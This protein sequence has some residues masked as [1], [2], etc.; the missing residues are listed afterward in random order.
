M[1]QTPLMVILRDYRAEGTVKSDMVSSSDLGRVAN[2][3][4]LVRGNTLAGR[5]FTRLGSWYR[6]MMTDVCAEY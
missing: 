2:V 3:R 4:L 5:L 6:L 1:L